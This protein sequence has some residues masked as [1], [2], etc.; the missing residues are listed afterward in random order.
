MTGVVTA[1]A[2]GNIIFNPN[3]QSENIADKNK[4][5]RISDYWKLF[6]HELK[7]WGI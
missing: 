1:Y 5:F 3:V 7:I 6:I 2:N 4:L